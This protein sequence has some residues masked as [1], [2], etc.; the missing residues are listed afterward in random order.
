ME[1][2]RSLQLSMAR[3]VCD[4]PPLK[5]ATHETYHYQQITLL[6]WIVKKIIEKKV[7][8][9][10]PLHL[11]DCVCSV[12]VVTGLLAS[13]VMSWVESSKDKKGFMVGDNVWTSMISY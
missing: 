11:M 9:H 7:E 5:I 12:D 2:R 8:R 4:K 6:N 10:T 13:M 1:P 3:P